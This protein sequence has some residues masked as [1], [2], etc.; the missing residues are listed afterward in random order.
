MN[1][2]KIGKDLKDMNLKTL[3]L[4]PSK[5]VIGE[6]IIINSNINR[7]REQAKTESNVVNNEKNRYYFCH[8]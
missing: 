7:R 5:I 8:G 4:S 2:L 6:S 1:T 3:C